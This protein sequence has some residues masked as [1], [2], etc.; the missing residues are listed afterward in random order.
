MCGLVGMAGDVTGAWKDVFNQ[1]LLFDSVRGMHST[2]TAFVRRFESEMKVVKRVGHPF[3]LFNSDEYND[4]MATKNTYKVL[5]GHNRH[6]TTGAKTEVNAHPFKFD[7]IV[8]AHNGTLEHLSVKDLHN[9]KQVDTDSEAIF[10]TIN[11]FGFDYTIGKLA[12]AWAL[13]FYDKKANTINFV[14]NSKRPLHY[15]YSAD[16]CTL[17]WASELEM[18][19]YVL[20][21][22]GKKVEQEEVTNEDGTT[23]KH[24]KFYEVHLDT[25]Y[26]WEIP[27]SVAKKFPL[28][29]QKD[30]KGVEKTSNVFFTN[31]K[32]QQTTTQTSVTDIG[33]NRHRGTNAPLIDAVPFNLRPDPKKFR[34]PYKDSYGHVMTKPQYTSMVAEG[35]A[36]CNEDNQDWGSFVHVLGHYQG[37]HTPYI[38]EACYNDK[39]SYDLVKWAI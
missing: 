1:L 30:A 24:D 8:G 32:A 19:K 4:A 38:C 22:A 27:D 28:P 34:P 12:G 26:S 15:C 17:I 10:A 2:G 14:R 23:T 33:G 29:T 20:A 9:Y 6:A 5:I 31:W 35:C 11:K 39:D 18:L 13:T 7:N 16:R 36:L 3:N 21:R 25:L 37:Y